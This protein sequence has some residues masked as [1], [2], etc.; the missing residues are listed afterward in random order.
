MKYEFRVYG[1][2]NT[3]GW[4]L[5]TKIKK[6][7]YE[8]AKEEAETLD[9]IKYSQYIIIGYD[10][11]TNTPIKTDYRFLDYDKPKTLTKKVK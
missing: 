11:K 5:I 10:L 3:N 8:T 4:E 9:P 7:D 6:D 2:S 1:N